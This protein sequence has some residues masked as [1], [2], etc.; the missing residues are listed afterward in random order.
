MKYGALAVDSGTVSLKW[1]TTDDEIHL[2]WQEIGG[3]T[4]LKPTRK[5]LGSKLLTPNGAL[6]NVD[7]NYHSAGVIC[8]LTVPVAQPPAKPLA[9]RPT[10]RTERPKGKPA[11]P[12]KC[13]S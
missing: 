13:A 10:D 1:T 11:S 3:P 2:L 4:V 5:G 12:P 7:I 6:Y 9:M 8:R